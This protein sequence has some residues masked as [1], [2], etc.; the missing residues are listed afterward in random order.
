MLS[1]VAVIT[2]KCKHCTGMAARAWSPPHTTGGK[3]VTG[4]IDEITYFYMLHAFDTKVRGTFYK[5]PTCIEHSPNPSICLLNFDVFGIAESNPFFSANGDGYMGLGL[6]DSLGDNNEYSILSQLKEHGLINKKIFSIYTQMQNQTD[7]PS[8]IRFG[9]ANEELYEG[10]ELHWLSTVNEKSW[11]VKMGQV[12]YGKEDILGRE[13]VALMNPSFPFIAAPYDDF[14]IFRD[15]VNQTGLGNYYNMTCTALDWCYFKTKCS[16]IADKLPELTFHL[17]AGTEKAKF[18]MKPENYIF[19][20]SN[21]EKEIENCH[22]AIIGQDFSNVNYWILGDIF[23]YNFYTSFDAENYPRIGLALQVAAGAGGNI[24][25]EPE[26]KGR[27]G[28]EPVK[29]PH[30]ALRNVL[31]VLIM[32]MCG[33][34]CLYAICTHQAKSKNRAAA[35]RVAEY[36]SA[37]KRLDGMEEDAEFAMSSGGNNED[38][39]EP[40]IP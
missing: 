5:L 22:L 33:T 28:D 21:P 32:I 8:Q 18:T 23:N 9:A 17:G 7:T 26:S 6:G 36:E 30:K 19:S 39:S 31:I 40:M 16:N 20:E 11:Q 25:P 38:Q 3:N 15:I 1:E 13:T 29:K 2:N 27:G 34:C 14:M 12:D 4:E 10:T 35:R 24:T 37:R